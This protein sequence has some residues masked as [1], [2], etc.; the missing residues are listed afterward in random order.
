MVPLLVSAAMHHATLPTVI[1]AVIGAIDPHAPL[2]AVAGIGIDAAIAI[3][4]IVDRTARGV[5]VA[6]IVAIPVR[7]I[8]VAIIARIG[9]ARPVDWRIVDRIAVAIIIGRVAIA[10]SAIGIG[11]VGDD[12]SGQRAEGEAGHR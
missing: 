4:A 7:P 8:A 9:V 12:R 11:V 6:A 10:V 2:A 3:T 5:S 1:G